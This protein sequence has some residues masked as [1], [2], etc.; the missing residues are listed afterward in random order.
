MLSL[1]IILYT[2]LIIAFFDAITP[3]PPRAFIFFRSSFFYFRHI[4]IF[5]TMSSDVRAC[6]RFYF[7]FSLPLADGHICRAIF[8]A[9]HTPCLLLICHDAISAPLMLLFFSPPLRLVTLLR[10]ASLRCADATPLMSLFITPPFFI[11]H[12]YAIMMPLMMPRTCY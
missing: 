5:A 10:R 12:Y 11:C 7:F 9:A 6:C 1:L 4:N 8:L 2:M 3:P